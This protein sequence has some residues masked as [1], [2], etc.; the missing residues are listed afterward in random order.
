MCQV[1]VKKNVSLAILKYFFKVSGL[2]LQKK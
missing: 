2:L 1:E